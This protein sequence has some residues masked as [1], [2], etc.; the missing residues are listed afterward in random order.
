[1]GHRVVRTLRG[2]P[3]IRMTSKRT[4][5]VSASTEDRSLA[6]AHHVPLGG[7]VSHVLIVQRFAPAF[8]QSCLWL[9]R[10]TRGLRLQRST[11]LR[12][13]TRNRQARSQE[14]LFRELFW[15][16]SKPRTGVSEDQVKPMKP[17]I[18]CCFS[19]GICDISPCIYQPLWGFA[20]GASASMGA[21]R[22]RGRGRADG[23]RVYVRQW[24]S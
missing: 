14:S 21:S 9:R 12:L 22:S 24:F 1:M 17:R 7:S 2:R 4:A 6:A 16:R 5:N 19:A 15:E 11:R 10:S 13:L 18:V 20:E 3:G 23:A 8:A